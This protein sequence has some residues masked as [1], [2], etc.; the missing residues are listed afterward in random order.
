MIVVV[1]DTSC[2]SNLIVIEELDLLGKVYEKIVIPEKVNLEILAIEEFGV[3]VSDYL[4]A[5]WITISSP[6]KTHIDLV[7]TY[8]LD[9]GETHA[10]ALGLQIHAD[11]MLM[12]E[13]DGRRVANHL[14]LE[15]TG[16]LGVVAKAKKL[17]VVH[18]AKVIFDRL[19]NEAGFRVS[20]SLYNKVLKE[21]GEI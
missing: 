19:I 1:S 14:G 9:E 15:T 2:I 6:D 3:D 7:S 13:L 8:R 10:I 12:D 20:K 21:L 5:K 11:V 4:S 16:L 17:G 18:S